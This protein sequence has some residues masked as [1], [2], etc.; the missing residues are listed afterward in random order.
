M[1]TN[2]YAREGICKECGHAKKETHIGKSSGGWTFSF[3]ASEEMRS[4][5]LWYM[6]LN[7]KDVKIFDEYDEE[8]SLEE[9]KKLVESKRNEKHNHAREYP[10][11]CFLDSEG[12]SFHKGEFS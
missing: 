9:F 4:A 3:H 8:I 7:Q 1:G 6:F 10:K 12:N 2:Y 5:K 11:G